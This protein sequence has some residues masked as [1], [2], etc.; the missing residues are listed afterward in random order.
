VAWQRLET[1]V[2]ARPGAVEPLVSSARFL[3]QEGEARLSHVYLRRAERL[4][5]KNPTVTM[6]RAVIALHQGQYRRASAA[7]E[8]ALQCGLAVEEKAQ[9]YAV[10]ASI[11]LHRGHR[12]DA[13]KH[14]DLALFLT[15]ESGYLYY[16]R[17]LAKRSLGKKEEARKDLE[18]AL[19]F[20]P[21]EARRTAIGRELGHME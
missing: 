6:T 20:E 9:M 18:E 16:S 12:E 7:A 11:H 14:Y 2:R 4:A 10:L 17:A 8:W 19:R 21:D 13:I 1:E 5:P 15:P 3:F